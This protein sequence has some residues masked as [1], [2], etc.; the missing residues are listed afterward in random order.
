[1]NIN[2]YGLVKVIAG[3][4]KEKYFMIYRMV[5]DKYALICDGRGRKISN[6][7]K[8]KIKHLEILDYTLKELREKSESGKE[9]SNSEVRKSIRKAKINLGILSEE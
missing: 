9:I 1:M 4:E 7:K 8:K 5:D 3:K 2:P 6:P